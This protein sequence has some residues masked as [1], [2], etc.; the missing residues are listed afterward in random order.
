M[1]TYHYDLPWP[2]KVLTSAELHCHVQN[3]VIH[4]RAW[5]HVGA[6]SCTAPRP[7]KLFI[8][9]PHPT[10]HSSQPRHQANGSK[11]AP[12]C[13]DAPDY[14]R[15]RCSDDAEH[16]PRLSRLLRFNGSVQQL[17]CLHDP[18]TTRPHDLEILLNSRSPKTTVADRI[19][20][21]SADPH[22]EMD[23]RN[24]ATGPT[25]YNTAGSKRL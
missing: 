2:S 23:R 14:A 17:Y 7:I 8:S 6:Y 21:R 12:R 13:D 16:A 4:T 5:L 1:T 3:I 9:Y 25:Y 24:G 15:I 18:F 20:A 22:R 10:L 19:R 11:M